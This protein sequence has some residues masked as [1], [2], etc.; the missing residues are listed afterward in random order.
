[1]SHKLLLLRTITEVLLLL[2]LVLYTLLSLLTC[3]SLCCCCCI[4]HTEHTECCRRRTLKPSVLVNVIPVSTTGQRNPSN[5]RIEQVRYPPS[6]NSHW[7]N[8]QDEHR[9]RKLWFRGRI[10]YSVYTSTP[11]AIQKHRT[12]HL[13]SETCKSLHNLSQSL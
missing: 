10:V 9:P 6:T 5:H 4:F 3:Y 2:L 1:M 12:D 8:H 13:C 7:T 11:L